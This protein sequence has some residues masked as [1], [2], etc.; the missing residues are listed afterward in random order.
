VNGYTFTIEDN[1]LFL[2]AAG[3]YDNTVQ[4][5]VS[6]TGYYWSFTETSSEVLAYSL[7]FSSTSINIY[8]E[9]KVNELNV[10]PFH[11]LN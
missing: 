4:L 8:G 10:R 5:D 9:Y 1:T 11:A 2:P 3:Y 7:R 6:T